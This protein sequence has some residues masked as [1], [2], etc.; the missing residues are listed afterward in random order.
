MK[1]LLMFGA[2]ALLASGFRSVQYFNP[3]FDPLSEETEPAPVC[4]VLHHRFLE[5]LDASIY[6]ESSEVV[7]VLDKVGSFTA[8]YE[9]LVCA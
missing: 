5:A 2:G 7:L 3:E 6:S 4:T 1:K 8:F 9:S